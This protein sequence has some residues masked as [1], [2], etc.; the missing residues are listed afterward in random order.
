[1][2]VDKLNAAKRQ[3]ATAIWLHLEDRDPVSVHTIA[4]AAKE[5]VDKLCEHNGVHNQIGRR[6]LLDLVLPERQKEVGDALN[7]SRNFFKHLGANPQEVIDF[8]ENENAMVIASAAVGLKELGINLVELSAFHG[9]LKIAVPRLFKPEFREYVHTFSPELIAET[10]AE[11]KAIFLVY[12]RKSILEK[13]LPGGFQDGD[14]AAWPVELKA[15]SH[16]DLI[17]PSKQPTIHV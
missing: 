16:M 11:K 6:Q 7:R 13:N 14:D 17:W 3:L 12:L 15:S 4:S 10:P 2:I 5:I 1:M 9:W 8:N